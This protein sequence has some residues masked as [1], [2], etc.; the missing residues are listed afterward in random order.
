MLGLP[1]GSV[2]VE[3][4]VASESAWVSGAIEAPP[5][6]RLR[7]CLRLAARLL[8]WSSH[9]DFSLDGQ[10]C[11]ETDLNGLTCWTE[12]AFEL[13]D[14]LVCEDWVLSWREVANDCNLR[15]WLGSLALC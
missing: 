4:F 11:W 3:A 6:A 7:R 9:S 15:I 8:C 1:A 12:T 13:V 10:T 14:L 5:L 2:L